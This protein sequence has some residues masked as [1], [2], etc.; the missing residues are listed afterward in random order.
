[1]R[2]IHYNILESKEIYTY[3]N[4]LLLVYKHLGVYYTLWTLTVVIFS[5]LKNI[6]TV[7]NHLYSVYKVYNI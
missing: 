2:K 1:M 5:T 7:I 4:I 6:D 3:I